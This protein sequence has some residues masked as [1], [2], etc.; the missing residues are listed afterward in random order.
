MSPIFIEINKI[1]IFCNLLYSTRGKA[2]EAAQ[3]SMKLTFCQACGHIFNLA[4]DP[5]LLQYDTGYE[6]SLHFSPCF[7]QYVKSTAANLISAYHLYGKDIIEIGCGKG[8]FI[9]LLCENGQNRGLGFDPSYVTGISNTGSSI[10]FIKDY[11][12]EKY[13]RIGQISSAPGTF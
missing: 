5:D 9:N 13:V 2:L 4:F 12:S 3:G 11:Y 1:P 6:N 10:K 7:Q 8:E